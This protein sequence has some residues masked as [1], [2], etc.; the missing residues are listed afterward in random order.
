MI[1]NEILNWAEDIGIL[2]GATPL[3]QVGELTEELAELI[4]AIA[5]HNKDEIKDAIGDMTV[6]LILLAELCELSHLE[7]VESAYD[8]LNSR[9][10]KM[11]NGV[12]VKDS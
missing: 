4:L 5:A 3:S 12:F 8:V 2:N 11:V 6:V 1:Q 7:C 10:G 9:T